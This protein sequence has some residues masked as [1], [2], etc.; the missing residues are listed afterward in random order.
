MDI[1]LQNPIILVKMII[2]MIFIDDDLFMYSYT[3]HLTHPTNIAA[4]DK[5]STN[6]HWM[7]SIIGYTQYLEDRGIFSIH[8]II[9]EWWF[10]TM[11]KVKKSLV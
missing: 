8:V 11:K 1:K 7:H 5:I 4:I 3:L 6:H 10:N 9:I 2:S